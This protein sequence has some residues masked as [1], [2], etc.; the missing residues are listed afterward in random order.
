MIS[1]LEKYE[2]NQDFHQI[3][4]FVEAS[5]IRYALTFNPTVYVSHIRQFWSTA[6][7]ETTE[8]GTKI[9]ATVDGQFSHQWKYLIH[10]IMQCLSP[11]STGFNEFSSNITTALVCLATNRVYNFSKMIFDGMV[12]N[13]NNKVSKFL[14]YPRQYTKRARIVQSST[15]PPIADEH[16]SPIGDDSQGK[17]CPTDFGLAAKQ[18]RVNITKTST[19]PSDSTLRVT[20][21]AADE[22]NMQQKLNELTALC[23]SLQRQQSEMASKFTAQDLEISQLKARVK[24]LEDREGGGIA[25]SREYASIKGRSLDE[26]EEAAKKGSDDTEEMVTVLTSL[27]AAT[28]L[29]SGVSVS[30][31]PVNEVYVAEVPT[32]SSSIPTASPPGTG[33]PTGSDVVPNASPIFTTATVAT[34][35][36]R[37]KAREMEEQMMREDQ[38]RNEQIE[39]DAEIAR[40]HAEE[41]LQMMIDGLDRNNETVAKYLQEYYQFAG[42][43]PIGERIDLISN[44]VKYQ[45]NYAKVLK[46]QTQQRKPLSRKQQKEFY[47]SVLKSHTGWK[48]RHFKGMTLEEIKE[49]FDPVWKQIQDFIPIGSKEESERFKRKGL[50]LEQDSAKKL[51]TSEE[52]PKEKLKEMIELIPVEEVYVEALQVKHPIIDWEVHTKG[53]RSYWKIIMLGGNTTSYQFFVDLLKHFKREDLNQLWAFVKETLNIRPATN[54]KEKKLWVELKRLTPCPIKGV[55]R[56]KK[57][58]AGLHDIDAVQVCLLIVAELVF[59]GKEDRNCISRH[60]VTLVEDLDTWNDYLWG[61]YMWAKFYERTVNIVDEHRQHHLDK[62]RKNPNYNATYNL[63]GFAWAFKDSILIVNLDPTPAEKIQAWFD[64]SIPY[65]NGIVDEDGKGCEDDYVLVSKDNSVDEDCNVCEDASAGLSKDEIVNDKLVDEDCNVSD[66]ASASLSKDNAINE[67]SVGNNDHLLLEDGDGLFDLEADCRN[68]EEDNENQPTNVSICDLYAVIKVHEERIA[69]LERLLKEKQPNDY[70]TENTKRNMIPNHS[71][72]IPSCYVPD[73]NSNQTS[74]DQELGGAANDLMSICSRLD[75]HNG[76]VSCDGIAIDKLDQMNDY[77]CSQPIPAGVD[78]L[79]QACAYDDNQPKLD[80]YI[81]ILDSQDEE[82]T[83][84]ACA[85]VRCRMLKSSNW[86]VNGVLRTTCNVPLPSVQNT[87]IRIDGMQESSN[88]RGSFMNASYE[89]ANHEVYQQGM[90]EP[91]HISNNMEDMYH[92]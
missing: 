19:L 32:G 57:G 51:K 63:Y 82:L 40:I 34:P 91:Q 39:R 30:I 25:H 74:M 37:R 11:K 1:I 10:T 29:S 52:V 62:K 13:V 33:V 20:S 4:D 84:W 3:V 22:G 5:H 54:D 50:R 46:Y 26:G 86:S 58:W 16:A 38:R 65:F 21:L 6:R 36:T 7:I 24:L 60:L 83:P 90:Y 9:L 81:C 41:E 8:K 87:C 2:N 31:S 53:E 79:I 44:L 73:L 45:D 88:P 70:A 55:L 68:S 85:K 17:A 23:T 12:K 18:D 42:Y 43:F 35:N 89:E 64:S 66:D 48:A 61:E 80:V 14:M 71:D 76:K 72:D 75:M 47:M 27:D 69:N 67:K 59:M 49:K 15:L 28:V 56:D 92:P 77:N 78:A